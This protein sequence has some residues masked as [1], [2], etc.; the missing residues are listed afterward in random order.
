MHETRA[1]EINNV[2]AK[3]IQNKYHHSNEIKKYSAIET[4]P[5]IEKK[6][7]ILLR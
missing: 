6:K 7:E 1:G 4:N 5:I 3:H 2:S